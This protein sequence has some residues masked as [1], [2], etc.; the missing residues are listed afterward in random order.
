MQ[1]IVLISNIAI[2]QLR[3]YMGTRFI[4]VALT[5]LTAALAS[6]SFAQG[7]QQPQNPFVIGACQSGCVFF[8]TRPSKIYSG[9]V[10]KSYRICSADAFKVEIHVDG[11]TVEIPGKFCSDVNGSDIT[12][13]YGTA[14]AGR[15]P[16]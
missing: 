3:K 6:P 11:R 12:L 9:S 4:V 15:L 2:D 1:D 10:P 7:P 5:A 13:T 14:R 16:E 8:D